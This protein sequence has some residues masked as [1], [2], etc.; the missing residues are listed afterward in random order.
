M[1]EGNLFFKKSVFINCPFDDQYRPLLKILIFTLVKY[2]MVPR[3]ALESSDS[4]QARITKILQ[5]INEC[6]Y[7]IHD[8]SRLKSTKPKEF[9]RLNMPFELGID[10]G[11]R[12][13]NKALASKKFLI[14]ESANFDY[15]KSISD[16]NGFDIKTHGN[17]PEKMIGSVRSWLI[18]S[19]GLRNIDAAM[20]VWYQFTDFGDRNFETKFNKYS[21]DYADDVATTMANQEIDKMP[22]PEFITEVENFFKSMKKS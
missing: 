13:F 3:I 15:M 8:L 20:K 19:V 2:G 21:P 6:K 7:S 16:I 1:G 12:N 22:V 9:Y 11:A 17:N 4:G 5:L 10:F 18:E 14:L